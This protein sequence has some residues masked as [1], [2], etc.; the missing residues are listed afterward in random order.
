MAS[1]SYSFQFVPREGEFCLKQKK[2]RL[3]N[4]I[5]RY[6][7][8]VNQYAHMIRQRYPEHELKVEVMNHPVPQL[9]QVFSL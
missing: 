1:K 4:S 3:K 9:K 7:N 8:A 6:R 5:N 2:F